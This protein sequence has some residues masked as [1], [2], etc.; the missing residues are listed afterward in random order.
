MTN[1]CRICRR[2]ELQGNLHFCRVGIGVS[3]PSK[4]PK[5][6]TPPLPV[7]L[8]SCYTY[9]VH[10]LPKDPC[11]INLRW[12]LSF[13]SAM[14]NNGRIKA[15]RPWTGHSGKVTYRMHKTQLQINLNCNV[16]SEPTIARQAVRFQV[17]DR[18]GAMWTR[19]G[20]KGAG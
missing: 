20:G 19:V 17:N 3:N 1:Q 6:H 13:R 15:E 11:Q 7:L 16:R 2:E 4:G 12:T 8:V 14:Q 10:T 9:I 18:R 5:I